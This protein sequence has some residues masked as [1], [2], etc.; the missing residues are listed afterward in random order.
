MCNCNNEK[1]KCNEQTDDK[2]I[3]QEYCDC[4]CDD[5]SLQCSCEFCK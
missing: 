2:V 3:K 4:G 5:E 1:C